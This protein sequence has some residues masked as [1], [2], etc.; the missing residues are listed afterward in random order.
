MSREAFLRPIEITGGSIDVKVNGTYNVA[1]PSGVYA[2]SISLAWSVANLVR[3]TA[4]ATSAYVNVSTDDDFRI[5]FNGNYTTISILNNDIALALGYVYGTS[6]TPGQ[7]GT[8]TPKYSWIPTYS[9]ANQDRFHLEQ[10]RAFSGAK[11]VTGLLAGVPTGGQ[12]TYTRRFD[13]VHELA[14][15]VSIEA[16]QTENRS[17]GK[18]ELENTLERIC[19]GART[20]YPSTAGYPSTKGIWFFPDWTNVDSMLTPDPSTEDPFMAPEYVGVNYN[21]TTSPSLF[22]FCHFP[23][24]GMSSVASSASLPISRLRYNVGFDLTTAPLPTGGWE[25]ST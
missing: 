4:G 15:N 22:T 16:C 18:T 6:Y 14:T 5:I 20:S 24:V 10:E 12:A 13:F 7:E 9:M 19:L 2:N 3:A 17:L 11:S 1:V 8:Y 23:P 25:Y 21:Y